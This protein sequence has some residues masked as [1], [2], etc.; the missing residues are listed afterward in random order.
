MSAWK[1][2][3][4]RS[5]FAPKTGG[6]AI[7]AK[8]ADLFGQQEPVVFEYG[9]VPI[10][11]FRAEEPLPHY[12]YTTFGISRVNS[13]T[14]IAGTQT[15]L[16]LRI[17]ADDPMPPGWP[18]QL[19]NRMATY[20]ER[21]G[22]DLE[23]GHHMDFGLPLID[24]STLSALIFVDDPY[25]GTIETKTGPVRFTYGIGVT[26]SDLDDALNWDARGFAGL[27]GEYYPLGLTDPQRKSLSENAEA[28][29]TL[30]A[31]TEAEGSSLSAAM[32][33][34]M[35]FTD[36]LPLRIDITTV[37]AEQLLRAIRFRLPF[38]RSF[39]LVSSKKW[40][41][42]VP[43][44]GEPQFAA[45][46]LGLPV[47]EKLATEMRAVFDSAPGTYTMTTEPLTIQVIDPTT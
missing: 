43:G 11:S 40:I 24:D 1:K 5:R 2:I 10:L 25:L 44:T 16:T 4:N 19:L 37:A 7:K 17:P 45:D 15:E 21:T 31:K 38:G 12:F 34:Y 39:A 8:F 29:E 33:D 13:A 6:T 20:I 28:R 32:A 3:F 14:P 9:D 27:L 42:M 22:N 35:D 18:A 30:K 26:A 36:E 41:E 47:S 23:P 46:H